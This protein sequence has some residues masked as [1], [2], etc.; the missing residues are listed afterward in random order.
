MYYKFIFTLTILNLHIY[1]CERYG[2]MNYIE[3]LFESDYQKNLKMKIFKY[4]HL[5]SYYYFKRKFG[6]VI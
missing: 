3:D 5:N 2:N 1:Y 4:F 6:N